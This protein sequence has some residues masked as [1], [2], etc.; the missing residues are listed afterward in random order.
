MIKKTSV[1]LV[2]S[3]IVFKD[4]EGER[5]LFCPSTGDV[6]IINEIGKFIWDKCNNRFTNEEIIEMV[7]DNYQGASQE[8]IQKEVSCF[9]K[10]M[11]KRDLIQV[12]KK[13]AI[14]GTR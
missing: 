8:R 9:L 13:Q 3:N 6:R 2:N 10:E 11:I 14:Y 1:L 7:I 4:V 5:V 12:V